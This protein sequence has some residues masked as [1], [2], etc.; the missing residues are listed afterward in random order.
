M[1]ALV[2]FLNAT[3]WALIV[4]PFQGKDETDHFAYVE[5]LAEN[6]SLPEDEAATPAST[7]PG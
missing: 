7:R 1:C 3:A 6:G 2:A 4:P 5:Q